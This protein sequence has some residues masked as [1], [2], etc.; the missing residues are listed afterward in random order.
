MS[1]ERGNV[2]P[3]GIKRVVETSVPKYPISSNTRRPTCT[4]CVCSKSGIQNMFAQ[5]TILPSH[6]TGCWLQTF[7]PNKNGNCDTSSYRKEKQQNSL[8]SLMPRPSRRPGELATSLGRP[9]Y[10]PIYGWFSPVNVLGWTC[11]SMFIDIYPSDITSYSH[12]MYVYMYNTPE[13]DGRVT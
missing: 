6:M 2:D 9:W 7:L 10:D 8:T 4:A 12:H 3:L 11:F 1:F 5:Q 13:K